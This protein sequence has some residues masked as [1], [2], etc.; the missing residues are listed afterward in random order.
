MVLGQHRTNCISE[1]LEGTVESEAW[2]RRKGF[3]SSLV[4]FGAITSEERDFLG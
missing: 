3:K 1:L 2:F 4:R